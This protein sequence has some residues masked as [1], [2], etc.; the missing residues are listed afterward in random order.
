MK[1][2]DVDPEK[3]A[4]VFEHT[5]T[6]Y[7]FYWMLA[8]IDATKATAGMRDISFAE[9]AARM[10]SKA[11]IPLN[12]GLFVFSKEDKL[13]QLINKLI[14]NTEL[15]NCDTEERV[16]NYIISHSKDALVKDIVARMTTYVPYR[17]LSPWVGANDRHKVMETASQD[18][19]LHR[20]PYAIFGKA[21]RINPAWRQY[22]LDHAPFFESFAKYNLTYY[23]TR[24]NDNI[25]LPEED[26]MAITA[27]GSATSFNTQM[28]FAA[29]GILPY[30][31]NQYLEALQ[32]ELR[33]LRSQNK[34]LHSLLFCASSQ[35]TT[36]NF[37]APIFNQGGTINGNV[38]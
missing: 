27:D 4:K 2:Y 14:F 28:G 25:I 21:I 33:L 34:K 24:F 38:E 12:T 10:L 15:R 1:Q 13:H 30:N 19:G 3:L 32:K 22:L 6:T 23:L 18:F 8:L 9:M 17:F 26:V 7:K 31:A 35:G 11:W 37:N 36:N 29:E 16:R 20:C 5:T